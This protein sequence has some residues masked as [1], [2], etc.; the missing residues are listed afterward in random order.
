MEFFQLVLALAFTL[1]ASMLL[2]YESGWRLGA[3]RLARSSERR[4]KG[5]GTAAASVFGLLGL[6]VAFTFNGAGE[7]FETRRHLITQE[8]NAIG[9]AYLRVDLLPTEV[10]PE[11][12]DLFRRYTDLRATTYAQTE[13]RT[14]ADS[15]LAH[16]TAV[17]S[18]IWKKAVAACQRPETPA[19]VAVVLF[20]AL[21]NMIDIT[22]TRKM[23][24]RNH[25]PLAVYLTLAVLALT[26]T[27]LMGHDTALEGVRGWFYILVYAGAV[28]FAVYVTVDIEFPRAGLI[29]VDDANRIL[30][31]LRQT[32]DS[33]GSEEG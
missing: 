21:N 25:P 3:A 10:Q 26:S 29:R 7:R 23:A 9:T 5:V 18:A 19:F 12:R 16:C 28:S 30:V 17:Q 14:V 27:F 32:M 24:T 1:F 33:S 31:E 11:I 20:P 15:Q 6:I 13:D 22:T 8:A 2:T 4:V